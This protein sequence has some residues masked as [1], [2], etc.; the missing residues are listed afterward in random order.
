[1]SRLLPAASIFTLVVILVFNLPVAAETIAD[2]LVVP[3]EGVTQI[4]TLDDGSSLVG[5]ITEGGVTE[6][7]F[8]SELGEMTIPVDRIRD[9]ENASTSDFRDGQYWFPNPNQT[10]MLFGPTGRMLKK[11][12]GYFSDVMIF[13][14]GV[15][16]GL[17]DNITIGGGTSLFPGMDA[18]EQLFFFTPKIGLNVLKDV[19]VAA[20]LMLIRVPV[21]EDDI[22]NA[23]RFLPDSL[24]TEVDVAKVVGLLFLTGTYGNRNSHVTFG[25][26]FGVADESIS[27]R[28]ALVL[29]FE[30]R[31][32]RRMSFV[33]EN[34]I[35]PELDQPIVSGGIR[36]F[37]DAMAIDL[38][39][40][41]VFDEDVPAFPYIDFV[42]NF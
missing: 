2:R 33:S 20:N 14:P 41:T 28:P 22:E 6:I 30:H 35:F 19:D 18:N 23:N 29:G 9:I 8:Q 39:L 25:A 40:L 32:A 12:E 15:A 13:F 17:T 10:R 4:L 11:G 38:A 31:F 21:D 37:G 1:M 5:R 34:W 42:W 27:D 3:A 36:F 26:G 16:Y 24:Q 7:K